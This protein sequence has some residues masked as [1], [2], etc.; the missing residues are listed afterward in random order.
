VRLHLFRV[1]GQVGLPLG[2]FL[3]EI[4]VGASLEISFELID[5]LDHGPKPAEAALVLVAHD[6]P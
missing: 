4:V 6:L 3:P 5:F 2:G 1:A